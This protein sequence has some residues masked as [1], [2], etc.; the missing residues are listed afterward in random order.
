MR[1]I[2][3]SADRRTADFLFALVLAPTSCRFFTSCSDAAARFLGVERKDGDLLI[4]CLVGGS[5]FGLA[6]AHRFASASRDW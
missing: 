1:S 6:P 5:L 3:S 2:R 4:A